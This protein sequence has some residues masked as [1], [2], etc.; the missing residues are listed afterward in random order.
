VDVVGGG[1]SGG[2]LDL[3]SGHGGRVFPTRA[4]CRRIRP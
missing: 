2:K 1:D 3:D 4:A